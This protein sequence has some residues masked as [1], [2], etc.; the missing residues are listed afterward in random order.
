VWQL[1]FTPD[2]SMIDVPSLK[3]VKAISVGRAPGALP[4]RN[5]ERRVGDFS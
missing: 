2:E 3:I 5:S 4:F 1:A